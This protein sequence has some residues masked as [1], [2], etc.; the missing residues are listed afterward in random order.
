MKSISIGIKGEMA[1]LYTNSQ[2]TRKIRI[3]SPPYIKVKWSN[4][5]IKE[6]YD[7]VLSVFDG[8]KENLPFPSDPKAFSASIL[9]A[10]GEK[11]ERQFNKDLKLCMINF[12][13]D[14][15]EYVF[16]PSR[17]LP[18]NGHEGIEG[19]VSIKPGS[20]AEEFISTL[21]GVVEKCET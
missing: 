16:K 12:H 2:T 9:K 17:R 3:S 19:K 7:L 13:E 8:Y 6:K 21:E 10:F 14:M 11:S 20:S 18:G 5:S 4:L 15:Q 1:Y